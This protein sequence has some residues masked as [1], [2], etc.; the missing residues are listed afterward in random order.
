M[1]TVRDC[2][3]RDVV[4][5]DPESSRGGVHRLVVMNGARLVGILTSMDIVRA[6]SVRRLV[7]AEPA[8]HMT[9]H[10]HADTRR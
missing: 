7:A 4:T 9:S 10:A 8:S 1:L 5:M 3:T 6:V 2:M